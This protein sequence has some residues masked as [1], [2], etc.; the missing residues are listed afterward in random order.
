MEEEKEI[1]IFDL[2]K[3]KTS[4]I[5]N[6]PG[7][8]NSLRCEIFD[9]DD[10]KLGEYTRNYHSMLNTFVP[11]YIPKKAWE[12]SDKHYAV[13][14]DDYQSIG[15]MTLPDCKVIAKTTT[16][17]CP[18]DFYVPTFDDTIHSIQYYRECL[19]KAI[20]DDNKKNI[21]YYTGSLKHEEPNLKEIG[22][23]ILV[24][25]CV[26]G[27]D[28]G[29]WKLMHLDISKMNEGV[30]ELT[31]KFGYCELHQSV[32]PMKNSIN[33]ESFDHLEIPLSAYFVFDE[34][35]EKSGFSGY[36]FSGLRLNRGKKAWK[37]FD[38]IEVPKNQPASPPVE[39]IK[40]IKIPQNKRKWY[41]G[42]V[43]WFDLL[44]SEYISFEYDKKKKK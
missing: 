6:S 41:S 37:W 4:K 24:S 38:V 22:R 32:Y 29:G 23:H 30:I 20:K 42:I 31:P 7:E 1:T 36:S 43:E 8:W 19:E 33:W 3:L 25:G 15:I 28:S 16:H 2:Y 14:S 39:P 9:R 21:E 18:V 34:E 5:E 12:I 44:A 17:F 27:D 40:E 13:F 35:P 11:F 26:W 10:K